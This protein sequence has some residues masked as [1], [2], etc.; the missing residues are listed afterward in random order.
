LGPAPAASQA[1]APVSSVGMSVKPMGNPGSKS[2][3]IFFNV[4]LSFEEPFGGALGPAENAFKSQPSPGSG[5]FTTNDYEPEL[6]NFCFEL[7]YDLD[8]ENGIGITAFA[9]T[10]NSGPSLYIENANDSTGDFSSEG[11][12]GTV[13]SFGLRYYRY[14]PDNWGR[15]LGFVS[16]DLYTMEVSYDISQGTGNWPTESGSE[17]S[18]PDMTGSALGASLGVGREVDLFG[19]L[20]LE[21]TVAFKY[22]DVTQVT[23]SYTSSTTNSGTTTA[24][25][26]GQGTLVTLSNGSVVLVDKNN[27]GNAKITNFDLTGLEGRAVV[28]IWF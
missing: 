8:K 17:V 19:F 14:L 6:V 15:W 12:Y 7:G 24:G 1:S 21:A 5:F 3:H 27:V 28:N 25:P 4:G 23:G 9:H 13:D 2:Q 10:A 26:S 18:A 22:A 11:I 16:A 20:C